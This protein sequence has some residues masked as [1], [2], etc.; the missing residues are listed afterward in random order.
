MGNLVCLPTFL[1]RRWT[2]TFTFE[3]SYPRKD[4]LQCPGRKAGYIL[5]D[6]RWSKLENDESPGRV[7]GSLTLDQVVTERCGQLETEGS[8]WSVEKEADAPQ[9]GSWQ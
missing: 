1:C 4:V 8:V 9:W 3:G 5:P 2:F 7:R 6:L